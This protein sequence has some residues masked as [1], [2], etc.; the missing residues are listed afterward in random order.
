MCAGVLEGP[1]ALIRLR[2]FAST[3]TPMALPS[4]NLAARLRMAIWPQRTV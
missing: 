4:I 1:L 3:L 2:G